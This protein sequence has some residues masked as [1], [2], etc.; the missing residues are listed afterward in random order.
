MLLCANPTPSTAFSAAAADTYMCVLLFPCNFSAET[1]PCGKQVNVE[2]S[3]AWLH[4]LGGKIPLDFIKVG[5]V[6]TEFVFFGIVFLILSEG[7]L[8]VTWHIERVFDGAAP[9][10]KMVVRGGFGT[11]IRNATAIEC[12]PRSLTRGLCRCA[13]SERGATTHKHC[14]PR[15][16]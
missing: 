16:T 3:R 2:V 6:A 5:R 9:S 12:S 8:P 15:A 14:P 1:Y 10:R 11:A 13:D 7:L 4:A